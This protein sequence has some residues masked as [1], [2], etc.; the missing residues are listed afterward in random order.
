M[1]LEDR[2]HQKSTEFLSERKELMNLVV[3]TRLSHCNPQLNYAG[4]AN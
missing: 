4:M 2:H 3:L 1:L